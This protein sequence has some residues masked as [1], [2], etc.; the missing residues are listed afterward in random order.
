MIDDNIRAAEL[1]LACDDLAQ[2]LRGF[3]EL[4]FR[5]AM[6]MPADDPRLAVITGHGLR[7][8]LV[9]G[10]GARGVVRLVCRDPDAIPAALRSLGGIRIEPVAEH[11]APVIP[12]NQPALAI[13][14]DQPSAWRPGRADMQYRDLIPQRHGGRFIASHIRIPRGGPVPDYVHWHAIRFQMIYCYRGWVR[15]VYEDQGD[16]FVMHAGDCVIQPPRIRHRVLEASDGLEVIE[17]S[18]PAVHETHADPQ[19]ALPSGSHP[20]RGFDGQH[21]T[22]HRAPDP[23]VA[24]DLGI[25]AA[26]AGVASARVITRG[27]AAAA[28]DAELLFGFVLRGALTLTCGGA[29]TALGATDAFAIPAGERFA[30]DAGPELA[31][32]EVA[33]PARGPEVA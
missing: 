15:L 17:V 21:F 2:A 6:I 7:L 14:R 24:R 11:A 1:E 8:R 26:S 23:Y 4:G 9:E 18:C 29:A 3:G 27:R 16:P 25:A 19:L 10:A 5:V 13:V 20:A 28:H 33:L 22:L 31:W 12:P 30:L 32:L